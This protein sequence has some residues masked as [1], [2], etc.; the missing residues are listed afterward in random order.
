[1]LRIASNAT[2][3]SGVFGRVTSQT[4]RSDDQTR[5]LAP[6]GSSAQSTGNA[7][8]PLDFQTETRDA[9]SDFPCHVHLSGPLSAGAGADVSAPLFRRNNRSTVNRRGSWECT[10]DRDSSMDGLQDAGSAVPPS[11]SIDSNSEQQTQPTGDN[12]GIYDSGLASTV[13]R[14]AVEGQVLCA[15]CSD[16][17]FLPWT[18]SD[19]CD[20]NRLNFKLARVCTR[21]DRRRAR[22]SAGGDDGALASEQADARTDETSSADEN[23][24]RRVASQRIYLSQCLKPANL[25]I[26]P[27]PTTSMW[28]REE[29]M[30][31]QSKDP[32][33]SQVMQWVLAKNKP[34]YAA[35]NAHTDLVCYYRQFQS[36]K[37]I[38]GILY[39]EFFDN[40]GIVNRHQQLVPRGLRNDLMQRIHI[41]V[42]GH[43]KAAHK[44]EMQVS[45]H[46]FW[47]NWKRDLNAFLVSSRSCLEYAYHAPPKQG[48]LRP[49]GGQTVSMPGTTL[50]Q[51]RRQGFW[52]R[53]KV[54]F[55]APHRET[56]KNQPHHN[57]V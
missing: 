45:V 40:K 31:Q 42:L 26:A 3:G 55:A 23:V 33:L 17:R 28:S 4:T 15:G 47:P 48:Q 25:P 11:V 7:A 21:G 13:A 36:L 52:R 49:T 22:Q 20:A 6:H 2:E 51:W 8:Q 1:V 54:N 29:I 50:N 27:M 34:E 39:Q 41:A 10:T 16:I 57:S 30:D 44:N 43:A 9:I 19:G 32:I 46:G 18:V 5:M 12:G 56:K 53:G 38:N 37:L 14:G 35:L 24:R